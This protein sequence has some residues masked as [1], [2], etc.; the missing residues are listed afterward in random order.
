MLCWSI[1]LDFFI[2]FY[3]ILNPQNLQCQALVL[4]AS[5]RL[6][7]S[8]SSPP[9]KYY[10]RLTAWTIVISKSQWLFKMGNCFFILTVCDVFVCSRC[11]EKAF[12]SGWWSR[13]TKLCVCARRLPWDFSAH[14]LLLRQ[15]CTDGHCSTAFVSVLIPGY[16]LWIWWI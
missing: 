12:L 8:E 14:Y 7:N 15:G 2:L 4:C 13:H 1:F 16:L 5:N 9:V 6:F 3:Q 11:F 10:G